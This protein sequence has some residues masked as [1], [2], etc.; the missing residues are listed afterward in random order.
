MKAGTNCTV[1]LR[2]YNADGS[3]AEASSKA[4]IPVLDIQEDGY[5]PPDWSE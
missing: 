5:L 4:Q 2:A 1:Q 3:I